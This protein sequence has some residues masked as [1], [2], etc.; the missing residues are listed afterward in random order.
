MSDPVEYYNFKTSLIPNRFVAYFINDVCGNHLKEIAALDRRT[1]LVVDI[2]RDIF[3]GVVEVGP[4]QYALNP[5]D[6]IGMLDDVT[7]ET[8][9]NE[10]LGKILRR[11]NFRTIHPIRDADEY[12]E[13]WC[14]HMKKFCDF[15]LQ[16]FDHVVIPENYFAEKTL[17]L[18][19]G[20]S[21]DVERALAVN[22]VAKR[23]YKWLRENTEI[24]IASIDNDKIFTGSDVPWGGPSTTHIIEETYA[25]YCQEVDRIV[26]KRET[27][28]PRYM[29]R[30]AFKRAHEHAHEQKLKVRAEKR[31]QELQTELESLKAGVADAE[32][33]FQE[34]LNGLQEEQKARQQLEDQHQQLAKARDT[35]A[36]LKEE[37]RRPIGYHLKKRLARATRPLRHPL[38][39]RG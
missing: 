38:M 17:E 7:P 8:M 12:F 35:I 14:V 30:A 36:R 5:V 23:M 39:A 28:D 15:L 9:S 16:N 2:M 21:L 4:N 1:L 18:H 27:H 10:I 24:P 37:V 6:G 34:C 31:I 26:L 19:D 3:M 29:E 13:L 25:L 11:D 20:H 33:K 32:N 22:A